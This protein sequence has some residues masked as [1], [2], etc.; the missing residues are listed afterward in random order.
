M[1]QPPGGL[2]HKQFPIRLSLDVNGD[3]KARKIGGLVRTGEQRCAAVAGFALQE[4][5]ER[6]HECA[7]FLSFP[8][9]VARA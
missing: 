7:A 2:K 9:P 8:L 4:K 1:V 3:L 5:R 6:R